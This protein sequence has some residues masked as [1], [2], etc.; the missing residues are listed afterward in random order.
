MGRGARQAFLSR[1]RAR[2]VAVDARLL[3]RALL[4]LLVVATLMVKILLDSVLNI[5]WDEFHYLAQIYTHQRGQ[6]SLA[7]QTFHVHLFSW[8][9]WVGGDEVDQILTARGAMFL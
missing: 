4:A 1:W 9:V 5:N 8:L 3:T 2:A 7:F 6:L